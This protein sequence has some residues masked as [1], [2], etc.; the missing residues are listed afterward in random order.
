MKINLINIGCKVNFAETS[1]LKD[2]FEKRGHEITEDNSS[3]D[4]ILINTCTVTNKADSD[5][6]KVMRRARRE[7]PNAF[8]GIFGCFAQL[9]SEEIK[10]FPELDAIF[11]IKEKFEIPDI[12]ESLDKDGKLSHDFI[13]KSVNVSDLKDLHF[14]PA[15]SADNES[16]ARAFLK[17]QDGCDYSCTYC[18]IPKARGSNRGMTFR[19]LPEQIKLIQQAGYKEAVLTGINLGEYES[20][21]GE[22]FLDVMKFIRDNDFGIRFRISSIEPN[23]LTQEMIEI[24]KNSENFCNHFHIPLQNGSN[25][26]LKLMKR[27]YNSEKFSDLIA[28]IKDTIPDSCIG[29]DVIAGFPGE[30]EQFF[31][32]SY[33][34]IDSIPVSY[35]HVFTYSER[36][37]TPAASFSGK[38]QNIIRKER[39]NKLRELSNFKLQEFYHTQLNKNEVFL[40]EKFNTEQKYLMGHTSNYVN[41]RLR[42]DKDIQN[43]LLR[44]KF[45]EQKKD[46]VVVELID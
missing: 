35:L 31:N 39:T 23:L 22:K 6:R 20:P 25:D 8:I 34:L 11:G 1:K 9:N 26:V 36:R 30:T 7:A 13:H 42:S 16:R 28:R 18:T 43:K 32:D 3:A 5:C 2:I 15:Y 44:V 45:V 37:N 24:V 10:E 40:A 46:Y 17:I 33:H 21:S 29:I 19:D 27:R 12:I 38:V 14:D 41:V 4:V